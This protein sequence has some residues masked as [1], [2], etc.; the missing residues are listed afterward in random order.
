MEGLRPKH[1]S[2][3]HRHRSRGTN[4]GGRAVRMLL[5]NVANSTSFVGILCLAV[6]RLAKFRTPMEGLSIQWAK[7]ARFLLRLQRATKEG[8][9]AVMANSGLPRSIGTVKQRRLLYM[10]E[11]AREG[12]LPADSLI[13]AAQQVAI[14]QVH[15]VEHIVLRTQ[16]RLQRIVQRG[17]LQAHQ[18]DV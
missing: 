15:E 1:C 3:R 9:Q 14:R 4:T 8:L 18:D 2:L 11:P 17:L 10:Q 16:P 6:I 12:A 13:P 7:T 5:R